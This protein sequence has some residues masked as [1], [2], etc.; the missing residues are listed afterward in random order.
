[1]NTREK[2]LVVKEWF[3]EM[4]MNE[5]RKDVQSCEVF[6]ILKETEKAYNV[7]VGSTTKCMTYWVPKSQVEEMENEENKVT[8]ICDDYDEV[9]KMWNIEMGYYR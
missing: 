4:K 8:L 7:F 2:R 1:M 6:A 9:Y 5:K 3:H